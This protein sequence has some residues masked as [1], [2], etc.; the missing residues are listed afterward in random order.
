MTWRG[1]LQLCASILAGA[2]FMTWEI[3]SNIES[4]FVN[5]DRNIGT[6]FDF[7]F[8]VNA[9]SSHDLAECVKVPWLDEAWKYTNTD[10][11]QKTLWS[12]VPNS[13]VVQFSKALSS[14]LSLRMSVPQKFLGF[15]QE[16]DNDD[17]R[18]LG[19]KMLASLKI[20]DEAESE[21]L[22]ELVASCDNRIL[23]GLAR[24]PGLDTRLLGVHRIELGVD[25]PSPESIESDLKALLLKLPLTGL[26]P[27]TTWFTRNAILTGKSAS[28]HR[29]P[30]FW[31]FSGDSLSFA[32][33][34]S[35]MPAEQVE[36]Y[37]LKA[38][39]RH[40]LVPSHRSLMVE[41]GVLDV[42][43]REI[44]HRFHS[45]RIKREIG[46]L[47]GNLALEESAHEGMVEQGCLPL[48]RSWLYSDDLALF[49]HAVRT[50]ANLDRDFCKDESYEDGVYLLHPQGRYS[51]S[52]DADVVF[53]H[54]LRGG[55]FMT[56]RQQEEKDVKK[57]GTDCWPKSWLVRDIPNIRVLMVEYD[58]SLS[59]WVSQCPQEPETRSL[60]Y[61]SEEIRRKLRK[62]GIGKRPVIWVVHSMGGLLVKQLLLDAEKNDEF[63]CMSDNTKGI[64]FYSTPHLG[65]ALASYSSQARHLLQPSVEVKELCQKSPF[66]ATLHENFLAL[67]QRHPVKLLSFGETVPMKLSWMLQTVLVTNDSA[68]LGVGEFLPLDV[69]HVDV[70][71]PSSQTDERYLKTAQF[72]QKLISK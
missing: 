23:I 45:L 14:P 56:W 32:H 33:T 31:S 50:L 67:V 61:R 43:F 28:Q 54:G 63:R 60:M 12:N 25:V 20:H 17:V 21:K 49:S 48:L 15:L 11:W 18:I 3:A 40:S 9:D 26:D 41:N 52:I 62:A 24:L 46:L 16:Y 58:T 10:E 39:T 4:L 27:C 55:P 6:G 30:L 66:L 53:V 5:D 64:V 2:G 44:K 57:S 1:P 72:I 42:I 38:L 35:S 8:D 65:S 22:N 29:R 69:D 70:C 36:L 51:T 47:L 34:L 68:D 7:T 19:T 13:L 37:Y 71:K 59:H